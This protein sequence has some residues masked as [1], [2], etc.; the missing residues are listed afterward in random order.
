MEQC[1]VENAF[2]KNRLGGSESDAIDSSERNPVQTVWSPYLLDDNV[3]MP[4]T[5]EIYFAI[6]DT[7]NIIVKEGIKVSI[8][9][10]IENGILI[11]VLLSKCS[12]RKDV[13]E[14]CH[15]QAE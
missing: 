3:R 9:T 6:S 2:F 7:V 1:N 8:V 14:Y 12:N 13:A 5:V 4:P 10:P 15:Q 11:I